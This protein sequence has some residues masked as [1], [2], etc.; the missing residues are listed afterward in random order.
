MLKNSVLQ[1]FIEKQF[2]T[3]N[4]NDYYKFRIFN[5]AGDYEQ[6]GSGANITGI[7]H[8]VADGSVRTE[9]DYMITTCSYEISLV[10]PVSLG[11]GEIKEVEEIVNA[12]V[13]GLNNKPFALDSGTL[14]MSFRP[15]KTGG[16]ASKDKVGRAVEIHLSFG[17]EF[18]EILS[19]GNYFEMALIDNPFDNSTV[20]TR[21]F[22]SQTEQVQWYNDKIEDGGIPY[23]RTFTPNINSITLTNQVYINNN[24]LNVSD[25][26]MKNYAIIREKDK[27]GNILNHYYY[28]VESGSLGANNQPL[29]NLKMDTLQTIYF[30]PNLQIPQSLIKRGHL[31][32]WIDNENGTVTF[33]CTPSSK[34]FETE[35]RDT[36]KRLTKRT[37]IEL[38]QAGSA[39]SDEIQHWLND[40]VAYWVY[41]FINK[42]YKTNDGVSISYDILNLKGDPVT[43]DGDLFELTN[44]GVNNNRYNNEV[45]VICYPIM[46]TTQTIYYESIIRGSTNIPIRINLSSNLG[47]ENFRKKNNNTSYFFGIKCSLKCPFDYAPTTSS[48][49]VIDADNNLALLNEE[50][51]D[52][53]IAGNGSNNY[54]ISTFMSNTGTT[55]QYGVFIGMKD[56]NNTMQSFEYNT[57]NQ[58]T[59]DKTDL[60]GAGRNINTNPKLL[61]QDFTELNVVDSTGNSFTY[62]KQKIGQNNISFLYTEPI[63]PEITKSYLRL[64]AP[65]GLYEDG[66]DENYMGLVSSTDNSLPIANDAYSSFLAS[67]KNFHMQNAI[68]YTQKG[69]NMA[70]GMVS[71]AGKAAASAVTGNIAGT[72]SSTIDGVNVAMQVGNYVADI[73]QKQLSIDNMKNA[74]GSIKNANGNPLFNMYVNDISLFVE[75][76]DAMDNDKQQL[77]D[78]MYLN[79]FAY[80]RLDHIRNYDNIRHY[81]N[82]VQANIETFSG[83]SMSNQIRDDLKI[84]FANGVRFWNQDNI[85]Y[86][87]ENYEKWLNN[88]E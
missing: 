80:D 13:I 21:Y 35:G 23:N 40:N 15:Q 86:T 87:M 69:V 70:Y 44:Y 43:V 55:N 82:F 42:G 9:M 38:K 60:I 53:Q 10:L 72:V 71:S 41:V 26:L 34:L 77:D 28:W 73:A 74:P 59:F 29:F 51:S 18:S 67:N 85:D 56:R 88:E 78:I 64:K 66:T 32:R 4:T 81:F 33:D 79:G 47:I 39:V 36:P 6:K 45:G 22:K 57:Y 3:L 17:I 75:E 5:S 76:Y 68:S 54:I 46:K 48:A 37:K 30:N 84:R 14:L 62:D 8:N 11:L 16:Y 12:I 52:G 7:M 2:N 83:V 1:E 20:N 65:V 31:N 58:Y 50:V 49:I 27:N 63:M 61:S 24:N 25:I 19:N